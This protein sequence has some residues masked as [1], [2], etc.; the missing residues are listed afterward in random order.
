MAMLRPTFRGRFGLSGCLLLLLLASAGCQKPSSDENGAGGSYSS[1]GEDSPQQI[2]DGMIAAYQNA[3][4]YADSGELYLRVV[5]NGKQQVNG[6]IPF[7]VT[8]E[9]PN[10]IRVQ[11][12]G[13]NVVCDGKKLRASVATIDGQV[14]AT[15][16]PERLLLEVLLADPKLSE[17]LKGDLDMLPITLKLLL[18]ERPLE[19][20]AGDAPS[21]TKVKDERLDGRRC[22]LVRV[23]TSDG[24]KTYW[25]DASDH[26]LRKL[27]LPTAALKKRIDFDGNLSSVELW[28]EFK[29]DRKS[30][31]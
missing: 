11:A 25:I 13:A 17:A 19:D 22:Q 7:S 4:S 3:T 15:D 2:L 29:G 23:R 1:T 20:V 9:R 14:L 16:A 31:V 26:L 27:E 6:P 21:L 18:A 28:A 30:V 24:N 12:Y 10:K 5:R 8:F